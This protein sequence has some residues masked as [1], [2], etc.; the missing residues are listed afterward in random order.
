MGTTALLIV[1]AGGIVMLL[2]LVAIVKLDAFVS[3]ILTSMI[4]ALFAGIP[5]GEIIASVEDGMGSTLGSIAIVIGLGA[6][7]GE[8]LRVSGGT[9]QL[10]TTLVDYF[11]ERWAPWAMGLTG[12]LVAISVFFDVGL[13]VLLP[14]AYS[15]TQRSGR[16]LLY[17]AIPLAAG[18]AVTHAYIPPTPGPVAIGAELGV[19]LGWIIFFGFI[20]GLPALGVGG[21]LYGRFIASAV[22]VAVPQN[23]RDEEK[24]AGSTDDSRAPGFALVLALILFPLVLIFIGTL[25]G[26]MLVEGSAVRDFLG[27]IGHPFTALLLATLLVFY[28]LGFRRGRSRKSVQQ[29]AARSLEPVALVL[30][31]TGAGGVFGSVLQKSGVGD[32]VADLMSDSGLPPIALAF[33]VATMV[34]VAQGSATVSMV[35]SAGLLAPA[36]QQ[37][38]LSGPAIGLVAIA[39]ASGATMLSHV[40]DSGFWLVNRFL[41]MS[42]TDTL[43]TWTVATTLIG[44][45]GFSVV[46]VLSLFIM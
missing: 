7:F 6:M 45:T 27:F 1:A 43:K 38:D 5:I 29:I 18:L 19:D 9:G 32:A 31:V 16:S 14:L 30:L 36:I 28:V 33:L 37:Q 46:Y 2:I 13:I 11:G 26:V 22:H 17:Y 12:F 20:A 41:D 44:L 15:L 25:S 24:E 10:A 42:V 3:L 34:R 35:T 4:V 21:I 23:I 40:N 39:I 8:M